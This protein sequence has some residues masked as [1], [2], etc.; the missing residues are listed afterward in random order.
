[1]NILPLIIMIIGTGAL[2][3]IL[4]HSQASARRIRRRCDRVLADRL[5]SE[6]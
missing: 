2:L 1:M 3:A 4:V 6:W 5:G